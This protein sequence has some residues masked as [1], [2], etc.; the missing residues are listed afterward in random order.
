MALCVG[1][2]TTVLFV[3]YAVY[4]APLAPYWAAVAL[5]WG[6]LT[7]AVTVAAVL[8]EPP[9][10]RA[11]LGG[12]AV[13]VLSYSVSDLIYRTNSSFDLNAIPGL[14]LAG[15]VLLVAAAGSDPELSR[16]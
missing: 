8:L 7:L 11:L 15:A 4:L 2:V 14:V 12:W 9:I 5:V 1:I 10:G 13:G 16:S 3:A 6:L